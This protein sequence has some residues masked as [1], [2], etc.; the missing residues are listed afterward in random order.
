MELFVPAVIVLLIGAIKSSLTVDVFSE[1]VPAS[2]A[3]VPTFG[4]LAGNIS[5]PNV[6]CYDNNM[7]QR[8]VAR[9]VP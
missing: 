5:Y 6:L 7:F 3:P 8:C 2:D 4:E 1:E 9:R